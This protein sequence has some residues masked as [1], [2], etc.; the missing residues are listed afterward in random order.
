M[1]YRD[2]HR[3]PDRPVGYGDSLLADGWS[4]ACIASNTHSYPITVCFLTISFLFS[5]KMHITR[6]VGSLPVFVAANGD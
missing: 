4:D 3:S 6:R 1:L 5:S 2:P